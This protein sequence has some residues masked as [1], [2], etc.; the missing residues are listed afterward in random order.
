MTVFIDASF[1]IALFNTDDEFHQKAKKTIVNLDKTIHLLTSNI[2]L[3]ETVNF[4]F[5]HLGS[6]ASRKFLKTFK[7]SN[8]E[9]FFVSREIFDSAYSLLFRQKSKKGLNL[10]DCLHLAT[11]KT[12]GIKSILT[13][14]T[15]FKKEVKVIGVRV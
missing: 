6:K 3:A 2:A 13:F 8:I 10:F 4:T 7:I 1:L 15:A 11:M 12:L 5:C 14:D 9:E